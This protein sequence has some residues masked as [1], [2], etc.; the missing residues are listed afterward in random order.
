MGNRFYVLGIALVV[1]SLGLT[2]CE[3]GPK[4]LIFSNLS[5]APSATGTVTL[6][7]AGLTRFGSLQIGPK[8]AITFDPN[9]IE[10]LSVVGV[11]G[12]VAFASNIDNALGEVT[13]AAGSTQGA[14]SN[15]AVLEITVKAVGTSGLSTAI[16]ITTLDFV[17]DTNS[18]PI[19]GV[20]IT[21]GQVSIN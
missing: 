17:L 5:L 15:G 12:L 20:K 2:A 9:V 6:S 4:V 16:T 3:A 19:S 8:G 7:A 14:L 1:L 18:D 11:N 21:P 13:V 10:V